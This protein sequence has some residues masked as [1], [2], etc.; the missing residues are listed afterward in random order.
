M[1]EL[2]VRESRS[3]DL[4]KKGAFIKKRRYKDV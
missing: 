2:I 4:I 1:E 3:E